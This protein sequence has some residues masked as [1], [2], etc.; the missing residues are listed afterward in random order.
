MSQPVWAL[1]LLA[2]VS[3]KHGV[4]PVAVASEAELVAP[5]PGG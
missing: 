4:A 5:A 2:A 1:E 3:I